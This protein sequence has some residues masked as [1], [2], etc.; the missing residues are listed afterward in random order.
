MRTQREL[1]EQRRVCAPV[2]EQFRARLRLAGRWI[3]IVVAEIRRLG[4]PVFE[5][6]V[7]RAFVDYFLE[8]GFGRLGS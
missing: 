5:V 7:C 8:E 3:R 2:G 4:A 1:P 6:H